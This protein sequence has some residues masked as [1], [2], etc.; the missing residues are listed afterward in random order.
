MLSKSYNAPLC[1]YGKIKMASRLWHRIIPDPLPYFM[2]FYSTL[3]SS[4]LHSTVSPMEPD[5]S[6]SIS[7]NFDIPCWQTTGLTESHGAGKTMMMFVPLLRV[8]GRLVFVASCFHG[9][10]PPVDLRDCWT[11]Y[12]ESLPLLNFSGGVFTHGHFQKIT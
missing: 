1:K 3:R 4:K 12:T 8:G 5:C 6:V 10:L 2:I 7:S 9:A 11:E